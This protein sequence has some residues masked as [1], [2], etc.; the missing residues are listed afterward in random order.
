MKV[1]NENH[2]CVVVYENNKCPLCALL[3]WFGKDNEPCIDCES[4]E[5]CQESGIRVYSNICKQRYKKI[6][7]IKP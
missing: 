6:I 2:S 4:Y 1:C 5:Y 7:S 3:E